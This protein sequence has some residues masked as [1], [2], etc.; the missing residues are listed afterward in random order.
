MAFDRVSMK[1]GVRKLLNSVHVIDTVNQYCG[2]RT[3]SEGSDDEQLVSEKSLFLL[4]MK[5]TKE[6]SKTRDTSTLQ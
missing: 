6:Y 2:D 5:S 4:Q 1:C 3:L